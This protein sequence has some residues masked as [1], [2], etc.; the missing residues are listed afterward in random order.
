MDIFIS[1]V[2][3]VFMG[4]FAIIAYR[5]ASARKDLPDYRDTIT[6]V[7]DDTKATRDGI[8][9]AERAIKETGKRIDEARESLDRSKGAVDAIG[10]SVAGSETINKRFGDILD[11]VE[12]TGK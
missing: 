3:L 8:D 5:I 12:K 7:E 11:D 6:R 9:N 2:L 4:V 10:E 1:V